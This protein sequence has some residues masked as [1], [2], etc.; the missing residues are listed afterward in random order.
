MSLKQAG[1]DRLTRSGPV[2]GQVYSPVASGLGRGDGLLVEGRVGEVDV[3]GVHLLLAQPQALASVLDVPA[4][5]FLQFD[6]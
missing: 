3:L 4:Y 2:L 5:K 1:P 6:D